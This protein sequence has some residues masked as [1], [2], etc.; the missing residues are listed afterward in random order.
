MPAPS[1]KLAEVFYDLR[2][3]TEGLSR[4]LAGAERSLGRI[5]TFIKRN[6][7][8]AIVG[9]GSAA[10]TT[11]L[12]LAQMAGQFQKQMAV[13]NSVANVTERQ[14]RGLADGVLQ[15]FGDLPVQN[16]DELTGALYQVISAGVSAGDALDYLETSARA[17][18]AG[19]TD[20]KTAVDLLTNATNAWASSNLTAAEAADKA[21][22]AIRLGKTTAAELSAGL[23]QVAGVASTVGLS[24]DEVLAATVTLTK[25][26]V[27]TQ[28]AMTGIAAILGSIIKPTETLIQDYPALAREFTLTK[29]QADG[30]AKFLID[31]KA[32][33][34]DNVAAFTAVIPSQEAYRVALT[35]TKDGGEDLRRT[36]GQMANSTGEAGKAFDRA[37]ANAVDLEQQIRN[38]LSA[39]LTDLG[40]NL[41][42]AKIRVLNLFAAA[43][44][45]VADAAASANDRPLIDLKTAISDL[46]QAVK[47]GED[48]QGMGLA[49]FFD[50]N[51]IQDAAR[52]ARAVFVENAGVLERLSTEQ[53]ESLKRGLEVAAQRP[54]ARL[55][56]NP[57]TDYLPLLDA[58]DRQIG[59]RKVEADVA[60]QSADEKATADRRA[61]RAAT[62]S[63]IATG[64]ATAAEITSYRGAADTATQTAQQRAAALAIVADAERD[65]T[66]A[67]AAA[68]EAAERGDTA[69]LEAARQRA[70]AAKTVIESQRDTLTQTADA[71]A[72]ASEAASEKFDGLSEQL[73]GLGRRAATVGDPRALAD[74]TRDVDELVAS[75]ERLTVPTERL[76]ALRAEAQRVK[77]TA[78]QGVAAALGEQLREVSAS[79][80]RSVV[81]DLEVA[82]DRLREQY[83]GTEG[84]TRTL[85]DQLIALREGEIDAARATETLEAALAAL[86]RQR[87]GGQITDAEQLAAL[88]GKIAD[89]Q[90]K[91]LTTRDEEK[92]AQIQERV[93]RIQQAIADVQ[94]RIARETRE[95]ADEAAKQVG[96]TQRL[97]GALADVADVAFG[98]VTAFQ[99]GN[100]ELARMLG[101]IAAVSHGVEDLFA[102][103]KKQGGW[104]SLFSTGAGFSAALP[105]V[106]QILGGLGAVGAIF[107]GGE[108]AAER[109]AREE[110]LRIRREN[111]QALYE[112][113]SQIGALEANMTAA[114]RSTV[115]NLAGQLASPASLQ[116]NLVAGGPND[117][118]ILNRALE[119]ALQREGLSFP[120]FKAQAE[121]LGVTIGDLGKITRGQFQAIADAANT[122]TVLYE[123][124]QERWRVLGTDAQQQLDEFVDLIGDRVPALGEALAGVLTKGLDLSTARGRTAAA[125]A[126]RDAFDSGELSAGVA[127][128]FLR[129]IEAIDGPT[130]TLADRLQQ[131]FDQVAQD[132]DLG[133]I[134]DAGAQFRALVASAIRE[135]KQFKPL[136]G[137]LDLTTVEG[138]DT[139]GERVATMVEQL[140]RGEIVIQGFSTDEAITALLQ[141]EN[142]GDAAAAAIAAAAERLQETERGLREDLQVRQLRVEGRE[143]EAKLLELQLRQAA[144]LKQFQDAG[145]S[146]D[147]IAALVALQ[148]QEFA[149]AQASLGGQDGPEGTGGFNIDRTITEVTG[150]RIAGLVGTSNY[151][152]A[153][154]AAATER[155]AGGLPGGAGAVPQPI[156]PAA[157]AA[158]PALQDLQGLQPPPAFDVDA[159]VASFAAALRQVAPIAPPSAAVLAGLTGGSTGAPVT[160]TVP[161]TLPSIVVQIQ[162]SA[163]AA[164][165]ARL[166][167]AA[168]A[169]LSSRLVEQINTALAVEHLFAKLVDGK[170]DV[171]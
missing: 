23:S 124:L 99:G 32:A 110:E 72:R 92:R 44:R 145:V 116:P 111:T 26:A 114:N 93:R 25:N 117:T 79:L 160:I 158:I 54:A 69:G 88:Y 144:E 107:G 11:G 141:L 41:L 91:L 104:S 109:A 43:I 118:R 87:G 74:F 135:V 159:L 154:I 123:T 89:E 38:R 166:G 115:V 42:P 171:S 36:L 163:T 34:G 19:Q 57:A 147:L 151:Y 140:R 35:L 31:L 4:D 81:D 156:D 127:E 46:G 106:G 96:T 128:E 64:R 45:N 63:A 94:G 90:T 100:D 142:A 105:A 125:A 84:A 58:I 37:T 170:P 17:A 9:L 29:L 133:D 22:T 18:I 138:L 56:Q 76:A 98:V 143:D 146:A 61:A 33:T 164:D 82:L 71:M 10:V 113:A 126:V 55:N 122:T 129:L 75:A 155:A 68:R 70:E 5:A 149:A 30:L 162:G 121:A 2:A 152:L 12:K 120:E 53:L 50:T 153:R 130:A 13:V 59:L 95:A 167:E 148:A 132:L 16:I 136:A 28:Q 6:P 119:D 77:D 97:A 66:A 150:S 102:A 108:S 52:R 131:R 60:K 169:T 1:R 15:I 24:F 134:T 3:R 14:L 165:A 112:L 139:F 161:I 86:D 40:D 85:A 157:L 80:T 62:E 137:G 101:G 51:A 47:D 78:G 168:A 67:Q 8:V 73:A 39:A 65:L 27:P 7:T 48:T 21:F 83:A 103:A 49:G 20:T